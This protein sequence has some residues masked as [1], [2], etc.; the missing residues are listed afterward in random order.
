MYLK[1]I[2]FFV[3]F[4]VSISSCMKEEIPKPKYGETS[5]ATKT[6]EMGEDYGNL[7]GFSLLNDDVYT[8]ESMNWDLF[9][10]PDLS[11]RLNG[12]RFMKAHQLPNLDA[13]SDSEVDSNFVFDSFSTSSSNLVVKLN[14][15]TSFY[16]IDLGRDLAGAVL[17]RKDVLFIKNE[18][19]ISIHHRLKGETNWKIQ[20]LKVNSSQGLFYSF[21][22][23]NNFTNPIFTESEFY[24]G[25][26]TIRFE[27]QNLDYLVRGVL[28]NKDVKV[29][30][31]ELN[32]AN[33]SEIGLEDIVGKSF[34]DTVDVIGY[35]WK[36]FD[37][38]A[39]LYHVDQNKVFILRYDSGLV[40]KLHF[41]SYYNS[42]GVKGSPLFEYELLE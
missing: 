22:N 35:D 27:N 18:N 19:E 6:L 9:F 12:S 17:G 20:T 34:S 31:L 14:A 41:L 3:L 10:Y 37:I 26:Y 28:K 8:V 21:L 2:F 39:S 7:L 36:T 4:I 30:I 42:V 1:N 38:D 29:E 40:F 5:T 11:V 15:D 25:G 33:Y 23:E 13:F 32:Q 16:R 24:C